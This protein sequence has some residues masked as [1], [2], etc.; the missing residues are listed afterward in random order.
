MV[1][2]KEDLVE[3]L[4]IMGET[5]DFFFDNFNKLHHEILYGVMSRMDISRNLYKDFLNAEEVYRISLD[6]FRSRIEDYDLDEQT[7]D[8]IMDQA[9]IVFYALSILEEQKEDFIVDM[10]DSTHADEFE[11][12]GMVDKFT[13]DNLNFMSGQEENLDFVLMYI[14]NMDNDW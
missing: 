7:V 8:E 12:E 13:S 6:D 10:L 1:K 2:T 14:G 3:D 4:K 11:V 9:D 5:R